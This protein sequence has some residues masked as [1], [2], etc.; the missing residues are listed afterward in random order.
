VF[1]YYPGAGLQIQPLGNW[2]MASGL[3]GKCRREPD[4]CDRAT[5]RKLIDDLLKIRSRRG[6]FTTWE[7]WFYFSGGTPPWTSGMSQATA[8]QALARA[9][10][11]NALND[12]SLLKVARSGLG[13]F[14]KPPPVG[15]RVKTDGGSHYVL[16]SFAPGLRVLN[17]FLQS[18]IGLY[19]FAKIADGEN[20]R[21]LYKRGDRAARNEMGRFDTGAW[22]LYSQGGAESSLGY[23]ELVTGFLVKLCS[24]LKGPYCTYSKRFTG[25]LKHAPHVR[26][27][28]ARSV[29]KGRALALR[30]RVDKVSCVTAGVYTA[31]G[32]RIYRARV[33]VSRGRH[34][35]SWTA[36]KRGRFKL[37]LEAL[38]LAR[39]KATVARS[40]RVR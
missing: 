32:K 29:H 36:R 26:Y 39:N 17:G 30:F 21:R 2:G 18:I 7:Y 22:S 11:P 12:R 10:T 40:L 28:G 31:G 1:Q 4:N 33:K 8:I 15:V 35:L 9:S 5:L 37:K 34:S 16:Y 27:R 24:R 3:A 20:A 38:D 14:E 6:G 13:A 23:H 25:Y 19:D